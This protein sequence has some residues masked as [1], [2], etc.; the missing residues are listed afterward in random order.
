MGQDL[1]S[2]QS[3]LMKAIFFVSEKIAPR[4]P[5]RETLQ[6]MVTVVDGYFGKVRE[7]TNKTFAG[8]QSMA[9]KV[10]VPIDKVAN[11]TTQA[12]ATIEPALALVEGWLGIV[13]DK[14]RCVCGFL[15]CTTPSFASS[16]CVA[17]LLAR[18]RALHQLGS[19]LEL[20][21]IL[22][23]ASAVADKVREFALSL[24]AKL[25][26][27]L[28][29]KLEQGIGMIRDF[30]SEGL[31][32]FEAQIGGAIAYTADK[33]S[34]MLD[35]VQDWL[36]TKLNATLTLIIE[37]VSGSQCFRQQSSNAHSCECSALSGGRV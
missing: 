3:V 1:L 12:Y 20:T 8:V 36:N 25:R 6:K 23:D 31:A 21:E 35:K 17:C 33:A 30:V 22:S 5:E 27:L 26:A 32:K 11:F 13:L 9:L 10:A 15:W 19:V 24:L 18:G 37:K 7:F 4:L 28:M 2:K 34:N 14:V 16:L 29:P